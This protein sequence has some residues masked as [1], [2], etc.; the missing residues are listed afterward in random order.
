MSG[1]GTDHVVKVKSDTRGRMIPEH[2]DEQIQK[3]LSK[4]QVPLMVNATVGTTVLCAIDPLKELGEVCKKYGIWMHADAA[5][6]GSA[7]FNKDMQDQVKDIDMADSITWDP[8]KHWC[9]PM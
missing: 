4:N 3:T 8:H 6:G 2:L 1:M 9:V 5:L 7:L